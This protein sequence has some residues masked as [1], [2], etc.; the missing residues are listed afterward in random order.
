MRIASFSEARNHVLLS[1]GMGSTIAIIIITISL[2]IDEPNS[3]SLNYA[4]KTRPT[5]IIVLLYRPNT[6]TTLT[7]PT[8]FP[9]SFGT[10]RIIPEM[11]IY[12]VVSWTLAERSQTSTNGM[13]LDLKLKVFRERSSGVYSFING[14]ELGKCGS[15][16]CCEAWD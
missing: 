3:Q 12:V 9:R 5:V 1:Y 7:M 16:C 15:V 4:I 6:M 10:T 14:T 8:G 13:C 11:T 2:A